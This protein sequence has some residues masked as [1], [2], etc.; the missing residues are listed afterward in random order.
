LSLRRVVWVVFSRVMS[1][2]MNLGNWST[3]LW[4][5]PAH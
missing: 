3:W 4:C 5:N 2:T 1:F